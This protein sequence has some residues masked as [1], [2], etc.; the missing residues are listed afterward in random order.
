[1]SNVEKVSEIEF[2][3]FVNVELKTARVKEVNEHPDA[4]RLWVLTV[5]AGE[6][7]DRTICAGIKKWYPAE[8]L[9][10]KD[11][12]IVANLKPRKLR[13]VESQGMLLA[14]QDQ[15]DVVLMSAMKPVQP[16][17]RVG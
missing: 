7:N 15:D 6:E 17:L 11:I 13:G 14:V 12:I 8:E 3:Q 10:G 4:D 16:G 1:M 2:D 5:D 9:V